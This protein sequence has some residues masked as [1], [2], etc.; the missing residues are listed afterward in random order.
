MTL[1]HLQSFH[2][3]KDFFNKKTEN[4]TIKIDVEE[5]KKRTGRGG[6]GLEVVV[7]T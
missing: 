6:S 4:R 7:L 2:I 5:Q 1:Y 3:L